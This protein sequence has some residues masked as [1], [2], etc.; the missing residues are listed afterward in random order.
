MRAQRLW[1]VLV[2]VALAPLWLVGILDRQLWTPDEPR[3]ADMAWRMAGQ[4]DRTLPNLAGVP[5]V[6]KPPLSYWM[7]GATIA[8]FGDS[9]AAARLPN[10]L[11]ATISALAIGAL[12]LTMGGPIAALIAALIAGSSVLAWH[13]TSWLDPDA[14][15][16]AGCSVAVLGLYW[17]YR[18]APGRRKLLGYTIMHLGSALGFMAKSAPGWLVPVVTLTTMMAW[19]RRWSELKRWELYAGLLIQL[20]LIGA[21]ISALAHMPQGPQSLR[22]LFWNNLF[23]RF[24]RIAPPGELDY[25]RGHRNW[26]GRYLFELPLSFLPWTLLIVAALQRAW[27]RVRDTDRASSAW[28]FASAAS[29]PFLLLLSLAATARDIYA[30]PLIPGLSALVALWATES[31]STVSRLEL[32]AVRGTY[33]LIGTIAILLGAVLVLFAAAG[34]Q[35]STRAAYVAVA[36]AAVLIGILTWRAARD[37]T[38][39]PQNLIWPYTAYLTAFTLSALIL[40]PVFDRWQN[41]NALARQIQIDSAG[42]E[43]ALL[44]PDETTIAMLDYRLL[45]PFTVLPQGDARQSIAGWF[46]LHGTQARVLVK[47]PGHAPGELAQLLSRWHGVKPSAADLASTDAAPGIARVVARYELPQGRRYALLGPPPQTVANRPPQPGSPLLLR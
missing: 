26:P 1:P 42:H 47:L 2:L 15:L 24:A 25:T 18:A 22:E 28:R 20:P 17:G 33:R 34:V 43:L 30:A 9:A 13:V 3:E 27:R 35:G 40:F 7:S 38:R 29:L 19:E 37:R 45:T 46:N 16:L 14:A 31:R 21:W 41:L 8:A 44:Q 5:F 12:G 4:S 11:Y 6:E 39:T 36:I 32:F 23:G 10:L